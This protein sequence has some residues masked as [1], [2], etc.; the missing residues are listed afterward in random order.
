MVRLGLG[1]AQ[2][3]A[4]VTAR[5]LGAASEGP[6]PTDPATPASPIP[7]GTRT[8]S[9]TACVSATCSSNGR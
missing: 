4:I 9:T 8:R 7:P 2:T 3:G 1:V 5:A 6:V